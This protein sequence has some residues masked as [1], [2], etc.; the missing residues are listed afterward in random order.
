[1]KCTAVIFDFGNVLGTFDK[2]SAALRLAC[3]SPYGPKEIVQAILNGGLERMLESG[4]MSE[5]AFCNEVLH[6]CKI[7]LTVPDV[8][9][10]W[11]NIF[12]PNQAIVPIVEQLI[13]KRVPIG[14][15]SNT[16]GIH[17]PYIMDLPVMQL[18]KRYD[19][20]FTLSYEI[21]GYKPDAILYETAL[22]RLGTKPDET[23]YLD[24]IG[25]YVAAA[26]S[27]GMQAEQYDCTK[28]A[29]AITGIM[30]K[31]ELL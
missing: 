2:F 25:A 13:E 17:W 31:Y 8:K 27:L 29:D 22:K 7:D 20:P 30:Q 6:W 4:H 10:I 3:A 15:L 18:L 24:D 9:R 28:D 26:R 12:A 5:T 19:A 23:L 16:N 11:G 14:I 1:M 21:G